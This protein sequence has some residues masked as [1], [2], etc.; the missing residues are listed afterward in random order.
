MDENI[1]EHVA[2]ERGLQ[3]GLR[4]AEQEHARVL[5]IKEDLAFEAGY[6]A[7]KEHQCG[8]KLTKKQLR[9]L[10]NNMVEVMEQIDIDND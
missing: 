2:Y 8:P 9:E 3:E 5:V 1:T 7:G 6:K 10:V 4:Q